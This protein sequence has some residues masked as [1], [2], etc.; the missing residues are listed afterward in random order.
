MNENFNNIPQ[1]TNLNNNDNKK[2]ILNIGLVIVLIVGIVFFFLVLNNNNV[3]NQQDN[4]NL[5]ENKEE[6]EPV[7]QPSTEKEEQKTESEE[8]SKE[9]NEQTQQKPTSSVTTM[10][11]TKTI[12]NEY[13]KFVY[14]N[15]Y[16]FKND[17]LSTGEAKLKVTLKSSYRNYRDSL[18]NELKDENKKYVKLDGISESV[19]KSSDGFTYIFKIDANKLSTKELADLGYRTRNRS[20]V[21]MNAYNNGYSC[22]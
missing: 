11:C 19:S 10:V 1:N 2:Q 7:V 17:S 13:G 6:Q 3:N 4:V 18:I 21:R 5:E 22:K 12:N 20:S 15:T 9:E 14:T 16:K 8:I